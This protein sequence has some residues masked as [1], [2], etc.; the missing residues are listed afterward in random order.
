MNLH[1]TL[2]DMAACV[3][4]VGPVVWDPLGPRSTAP[5]CADISAS[6]AHG[7]SSKLLVGLL[8]W[9]SLLGLVLLRALRFKFKAPIL[10]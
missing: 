1:H 10:F 4:A 2:H 5:V 6:K 3:L 8:G 7:Q 9:G